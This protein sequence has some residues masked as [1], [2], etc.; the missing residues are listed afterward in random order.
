MP[1]GHRGVK[2]HSKDIRSF[3][4]SPL[5]GTTKGQV[6]LPLGKTAEKGVKLYT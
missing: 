2:G 3:R 4:S 1:S 5:N 6:H